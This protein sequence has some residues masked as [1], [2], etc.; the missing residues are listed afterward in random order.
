[1]GRKAHKLTEDE[2]N[3]FEQVV[4]LKKDVIDKILYFE[5]KCHKPQ[6]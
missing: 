2:R 5:S 1:M 6:L 4:K 3:T